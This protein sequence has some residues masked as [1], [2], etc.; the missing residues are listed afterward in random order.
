MQTNMLLPFLCHGLDIEFH[1]I[2][3]IVAFPVVIAAFLALLPSV[4]AYRHVARH[5]AL[6][7]TTTLA[8]ATSARSETE[9][10]VFIVI[11][12]QILSREA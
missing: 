3:E 9:K 7:G 4:L 2:F 10:T 6:L 11:M 5:Q 8:T 12:A 1:E